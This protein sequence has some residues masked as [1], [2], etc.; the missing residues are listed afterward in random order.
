MIRADKVM[1]ID[2]DGTKIGL[3][4]LD[5]A[6]NRAEKVSMDLVQVSA[7]GAD[8]LVCKILDY[9]KHVFAK[10]KI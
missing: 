10:K 7:M 8:P 5:D 2:R 4:K 6:L 9:G 3:V 1:L